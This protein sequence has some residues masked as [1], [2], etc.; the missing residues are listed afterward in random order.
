MERGGVVGE[1]EGGEERHYGRHLVERPRSLESGIGGRRGGRIAKFVAML[2]SLVC[3][4][5]I[6]HRGHGRC[7]SCVSQWGGGTWVVSNPEG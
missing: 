5:F 4:S 1:V 7:V 3:L 6:T 2:V